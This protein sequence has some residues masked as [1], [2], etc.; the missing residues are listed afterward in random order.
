M[1]NIPAT[2]RKRQSTQRRLWM[3][4]LRVTARRALAML[5]TAK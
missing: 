5:A 1:R 4:R 2:W 3:G